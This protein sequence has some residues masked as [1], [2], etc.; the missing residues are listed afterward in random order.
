MV[1]TAA[2]SSTVPQS[3]AQTFK[4]LDNSRKGNCPGK[5]GNSVKRRD[6]V[7][8]SSSVLNLPL[9]VFTLH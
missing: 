3:I 7:Q 8:H 6:E 2:T 9:Y 4:K 1:N 5:V